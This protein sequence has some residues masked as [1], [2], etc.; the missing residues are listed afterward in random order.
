MTNA[1]ERNNIMTPVVA[2]GASAGGLEQIKL[3]LRDMP[4][5]T[6]AA[7]VVLQHLAPH[8][9]SQLA[10]LLDHS[11]ALPVVEIEDRMALEADRVHVIP[12]GYSL[13]IKD[14]RLHLSPAQGHEEAPRLIDD[15]FRELADARGSRTVG[16]ILSGTGSDGTL[17]LK[18]I[19]A[20]GG[21]TLVQNPDT[22]AFD[23]MP[24]AAA[25]GASPDALLDTPDMV[26]TLRNHLQRSPPNNRGIAG[27]TDNADQDDDSDEADNQAV[28]DDVLASI[29]DLLRRNGEHDFRRHKPNMLKRRIERRMG[30]TEVGH[31]DDYLQTLEQ[32]GEERARLCGDFLISVTDF[33]RETATFESLASEIHTLL[34]D[35]DVDDTIRAWVPGCATGEEAYSIAMLI[36]EQVEATGRN[37]SYIVFATDVSERALDIGRAGLYPR[38]IKAD[39]SPERLRTF[40]NEVDHHYQVKR[41]LRERV[42]FAPQN[43]IDDPPYSRLDIVSCRNLL[44]YLRS[45]TQKRLMTLFHFALKHSGLLFLGRSENIGG[46]EDLFEPVVKEHRL[47]RRIGTSQ[48]HRLDFAT[49]RGKQ[50][51]PAGERDE[52][53]EAARQRRNIE[54][55]ARDVLLAEH[56]PAAVLVNRKLEILCGYGPTRDFLSLPFG[57]SSLALM[58]MVRG[59]FLGQLRAVVHK[60]RRNDEACDVCTSVA[61]DD[62]G[63]MVRISVRPLQQPASA[64]GLLLITFERMPA[65]SRRETSGNTGSEVEAQLA[66]ELEATRRELNNTIQA[67]E[68]SNEDLK[69]SNEEIMSMNEELQSTNEELE[70]SKEE[71][72]SINEELTT[73]NSELESKV[74]ELE[75]AQN[76]LTNLFAGT[77]I[78]T[79]F[80][81]RAMRIRRFTPAIRDLTNLIVA[82]V[83]RP[84]RDMTLKFDDPNLLSDADAVLD[85]LSPREQEVRAAAGGWYLRRILPYRTRDNMI[86]GVII[87]FADISDLKRASLRSSDQEQRLDLAM[88]A[89]NGGMWDMKIDPDN[90]EKLPDRIYLSARLKRLLGFEPDQI[91]DSLDAWQERILP[92]DRATFSDAAR[93]GQ[94]AGSEPVHYRIRHRDG[95]VRWFAS[96][97][98]IVTD[99]Q[100]RSKRWIGMDCDITDYKETNHAAESQTQLLANHVAMPVAFVDGERVFKFSNAAF[101]QWFDAAHDDLVGQTVGQIMGNA[102]SKTLE[103]AAEAALSGKAVNCDLSLQHPKLGERIALV[104]HVPHILDDRVL[105]YFMVIEDT[106]GHKRRRSDQIEGQT[107]LIHV[108]RMATV[109]EMATTLAHD[110]NQPLSAITTYASGLARMIHAGKPADETAPILKKIADQVQRASSIVGDVRDFVGR[111]ETGFE[112]VDIN[113]L[114]HRSVSLMQGRAKKMNVD[115]R[116]S[117]HT[118]LPAAYGD[119]VQ[120]EQVL[121]N[122]ISNAFDAMEA[123][124]RDE[125]ILWLTSETSGPDYSQVVVTDSGE[126][127]AA[128]KITTIFDSFHTT[129]LEG[130]G[131]GLSI[132]RAIVESHG[133]QLWAESQAGHGATFYLKLPTAES[134]R[135]S[136]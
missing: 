77:Q 14:N 54:N 75:N 16:I 88:S 5:D 131:M 124:D 42:V 97:G 59:E 76:D 13:G 31:I 123:V 130:M 108:H 6:G 22:A 126:G 29:L 82:D 125:R 38:S 100:D 84:L 110:L 49:S 79:V 9:K 33:F 94:S 66:D 121:I 85:D 67:L 3:L 98:T 51:A 32:S 1:P 109:G 48:L 107:N 53:A 46:Q 39:V 105:G 64:R 133:G 37:Y 50:D 80:L 135:E 134:A 95:S 20:G 101:C 23:G 104:K 10:E 72:Q 90:P 8:H 132:S 19:R 102:L 87:T 111:R 69:G 7:F 41:S 28:S 56:V 112:E 93:R 18:A 44:I 99:V 26:Q 27:S 68:S 73:V 92:Q 2:I 89:I 43:V 128:E 60:A 35:R 11:S 47:F 4:P 114:L 57:E 63:Q 61:G 12:A 55:I 70:T 103:H 45:S 120:I 86:D 113:A 119:G 127:I 136:K 34:R 117:I 78:A 21:L 25:K 83:G 129:K 116:L 74:G 118:P 115:T 62:D 58:D 30:L 106:T 96:Y 65:A 122:L 15:F 91:A 71:L 17:G 36:A 81:D 40:F 24:R 52:H